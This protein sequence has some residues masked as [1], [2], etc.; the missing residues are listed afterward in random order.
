MIEANSPKLVSAT[1]RS[2]TEIVVVRDDLTDG[3]MPGTCLFVGLEGTLTYEETAESSVE[4]NV[5]CTF[6][7]GIPAANT[8]APITLIFYPTTGSTIDKLIA[9]ENSVTIQSTLRVWV[10]ELEQPCSFAGGC[11]YWVDGF[12]LPGTLSAD[13]ENNF[14]EVCGG[15]RCEI[16]RELSDET[17]AVCLLPPLPTVYSADEYNIGI[18][19]PRPITKIWSGSGTDATVLNDGDLDTDYDDTNASCFAQI[20]A[21]SGN[22][23]ALN[24]LQIYF[25]DV[26]DTDPYD[27]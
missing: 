14:V 9:D 19:G 8:P 11:K 5:V 20:S 26:S 12:F 17:R 24:E 6:V 18:D 2:R 7:P 1:V 13:Q 4:F 21:K 10:S 3:T 25:T 27:G 23:F 22:T 15:Y 16:D